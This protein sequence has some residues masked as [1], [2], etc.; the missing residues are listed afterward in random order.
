MVDQDKAL[1]QTTKGALVVASGVDDL[2]IQIRPA[3]QAKSLIERVKR[4]LPVDPSSACQRLFNATIHDLRDK[5]I[6]AGL[7]I[8]KEAAVAHKLP[9]V[10]KNEDILEGYSPSNI[11]DLA[12]RM[13]LLS[14]PE[15]RRL[16]RAYEIRGDLEHEDD[17]YEAGVEDCVYIFRS[18]V[19]IVL[20]QDPVEL[21]RVADVQ[22]L[23][24]APTRVSPSSDFL[25][26]F[27]RAPD[28]RQHAIME[29]LVRSTLDSS[30]PDIIRQN[31]IEAI[32]RLST[33]T[34]NAVKIELGKSLQERLKRQ[35]LDLLHAKVAAAAGV[36]PYLRQSQVEA[37]FSEFHTRLSQIGYGWRNHTEHGDVLD[38]LEDI[39]GLIL[40]PPEP[41]R[42]IM[43]WLTICYLGE[44]G[45]YGWYG[46][47][48][49]V[50]YSNAAA[51]RIERLVKAAG[52]DV[53]ADLEAVRTDRRV[54]AAI[55]NTDIAR[56]FEQL[57][58]LTDAS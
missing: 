1:V 4:L 47:N 52:G 5:I 38:D 46:R 20:S 9:P 54:A 7:D 24:E 57:L 43:R 3:W 28:P 53:K 45:G 27:E 11:L 36:L 6:I 58:D 33:L 15:W 16:R 56:R 10:A 37:F 23:I 14:R 32:R 13:G 21:L 41:R 25:R 17:E 39:G 44:P 30:K 35:P 26:D 22:E 19:G 2:L 31:A 12:Y 55:Q 48:R 18:C 49:A 51:H 29:F 40:A 34:R 8:A 50:F 42:A